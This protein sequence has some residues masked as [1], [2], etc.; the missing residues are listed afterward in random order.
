MRT[1]FITL[2]ALLLITSSLDAQRRGG[3]SERPRFLRLLKVGIGVNYFS[4]FE[5]DDPGSRIR[6]HIGLAPTVELSDQVYFKPELAFSMKGGKADYDPGVQGVFD[7]EVIYRINYL[8]LPLM[9]GFKPGR[10]VALEAGLYGAVPL[11][12]N[13]EFN[14]DFVTGTGAFDSDAIQD[15]DYGWVAGL[16]FRTLGLRYYYGL[17]E[18]ASET[19]ADDFLG[20]ATQHTVQIYL[21]FGGDRKGR[22]RGRRRR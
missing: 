12:T 1:L 4:S 22:S 18:V 5:A 11:S 15:F 20:D 9:V 7:G 13:F 10:R 21:Q 19:A 14:G 8:E 6:F 2:S 3:G 16:K 17:Q